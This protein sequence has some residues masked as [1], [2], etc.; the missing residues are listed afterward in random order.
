MSLSALA[1]PWSSPL[2]GSLSAT[3]LSFAK[4]IV[5]LE[6]LLFPFN[7]RSATIP[8]M[9]ACLS[10]LPSFNLSWTCDYIQDPVRSFS[11]RDKYKRPLWITTALE[12]PSVVSNYSIFLV[13]DTIY[14]S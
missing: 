4:A 7:T 11:G 9:Y 13:H 5:P 8:N 2:L 10:A 14:S 3:S 6:P 1:A 12:K